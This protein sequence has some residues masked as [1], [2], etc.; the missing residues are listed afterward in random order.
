MLTIRHGSGLGKIVR[1][2]NRFIILATT[3]ALFSVTG[4]NSQAL[5]ET[6]AGNLFSGSE[7]NGN[8][9]FECSNYIGAE[10]FSLGNGNCRFECSNYIGA[11]NFSLAVSAV[12]DGLSFTTAYD[13]T[14]APGVSVSWF[15]YEDTDIA[16]GVFGVPGSTIASGTAT[17]TLTNLGAWA[18]NPTVYDFVRFDLTIPNVAVGP[19]DYWSGFRL[20]AADSRVYYWLQ[21]ITG[22]GVSAESST[23]GASWIKPYALFSDGAVFEVL[24]RF[25]A[26]VVPLP[27]ALPLL[28]G[29]LAGLGLIGWRRRKTLSRGEVITRQRIL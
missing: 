5:A 1:V 6:L 26:A 24:G 3:A 29:G 20:T 27:A 12:L 2:R 21:S 8:C 25:D 18:F 14:K 9:R 7:T 10:N 4:T 16:S 22:D 23:G 28:L 11:E 19:G 17:P 15:L 13:K